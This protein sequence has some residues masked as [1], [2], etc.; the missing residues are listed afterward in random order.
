MTLQEPSTEVKHRP[1]PRYKVV[2]RVMIAKGGEI[3]PA[4]VSA[5]TDYMLLLARRQLARDKLAEPKELD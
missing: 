1:P 2:N 4:A 5:M 3:S